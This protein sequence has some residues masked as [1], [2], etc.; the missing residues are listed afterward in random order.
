MRRLEL[1][2]VPSS[3]GLCGTHPP[4]RL[5]AIEDVFAAVVVNQGEDAA[6][7]QVRSL[8]GA[9]DAGDI[10]GAVGHFAEDVRNHG[11]TVGRPGM[12]AVFEAQRLAF[13]D[14]HHEVVQMIAKDTVV[15]TRSMLSGTHR[16]RLAEPMASLLF[17]GALRD[18]EPAGRF[19]RIQAIHIWEV[20]DDQLITA[21]WANRDDIGM[22]HQL[23]D[24][25]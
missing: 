23:S 8:V 4:I 10:E 17:N 25:P 5:R 18:L 16:A 3:G 24:G 6:T 22:R 1:S 19:M 12:R 20:G 13:P 21:H 2:D 9:L 14:W 15:V 11:R 7:R